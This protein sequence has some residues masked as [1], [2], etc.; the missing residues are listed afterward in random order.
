MV[1]MTPSLFCSG[2]AYYWWW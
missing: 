1:K 2:F